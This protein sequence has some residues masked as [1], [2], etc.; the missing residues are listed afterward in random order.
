VGGGLVCAVFSVVQG[1]GHWA[2]GC[3]GKKGGIVGPYG[4]GKG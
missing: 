3:M 4:V 1:I 2:W